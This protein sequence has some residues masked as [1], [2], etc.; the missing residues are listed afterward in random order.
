MYVDKTSKRKIDIITF[1]IEE[2]ERVALSAWKLKLW[3]I[4]RV[5]LML[6]IWGMLKQ[7]KDRNWKRHH[8]ACM[9]NSRCTRYSNLSIPHI[10]NYV[11]LRK[12]WC[13]WE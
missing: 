11:A 10:C 12:F 7:L 4:F 5:H 8:L 2:K 1:R 3:R 13:I 6:I 9:H